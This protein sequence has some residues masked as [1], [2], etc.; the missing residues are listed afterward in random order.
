MHLY[1]T[2]SQPA[3]FT[4][5]PPSLS[6]SIDN[7]DSFSDLRQQLMR[8]REQLDADTSGI[9]VSTAPLSSVD[10]IVEASLPPAASVMAESKPEMSSG[11]GVM[12]T[13][14]GAAVHTDVSDFA[15]SS[16][17]PLLSKLDLLMDSTKQ[18]HVDRDSSGIDFMLSP[19]YRSIGIPSSLSSSASPQSHT[20]DAHQPASIV[21]HAARSLDSLD[22]PT[23]E[24][25]VQSYHRNQQ[26]I[27]NSAESKE[28]ADS[29]SS[30]PME[31][32][33]PQPSGI[34]FF[35]PFE[36]GSENENGQQSRYNLCACVC[37][38][39]S[40]FHVQMTV[41]FTECL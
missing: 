28:S 24:N 16:W 33:S 38:F 21:E 37:D 1:P 2:N 4:E 18:F 40:I 41:V 13:S 31:T 26:T 25:Y 27:S 19:E 11:T 17:A 7:L 35:V 15:N 12:D 36:N 20:D 8:V 23:S 10:Q 9:Q 39:D 34:G 29:S 5:A 22:A 3:R 30:S 6:G 32:S 14:N